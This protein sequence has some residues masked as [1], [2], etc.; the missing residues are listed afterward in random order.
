ML[1]SRVSSPT[2]PDTSNS[3]CNRR[4]T[5]QKLVQKFESPMATI[6]NDLS[7]N[8][9]VSLHRHRICCLSGVGVRRWIQRNDSYSVDQLDRAAVCQPHV[10]TSH[11]QVTEARVG[12][13]ESAGAGVPR[14]PHRLG[15]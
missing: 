11:V 14:F 6:R 12:A 7:T 1:C 13:R 9:D 15:I 8:M 3:I 4:T 2:S 5:S 10:G